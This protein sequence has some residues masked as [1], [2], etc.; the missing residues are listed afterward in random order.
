MKKLIWGTW[1]ASVLFLG[2]STLFAN[3]SFAQ[4]IICSG[5]GSSG[6]PCTIPIC[7]AEGTACLTALCQ[8][9]YGSRAISI[10]SGTTYYHT[11][12]G[13]NQVI[14]G[15]SSCQSS[16]SMYLGTIDPRSCNLSV[17]FSPSPYDFGPVMVNTVTSSIN[18]TIS[19]PSSIDAIGCQY[20]DTDVG[21]NFIFSSGN[22]A[23]L[24][25]GS[26]CVATLKANPKSAGTFTDQIIVACVDLNSHSFRY[27]SSNYSVTSSA[28]C[29]GGQ[30][31]SG[32]AC[33]CPYNYTFA[34][35][36]CTPNLSNGP[37]GSSSSSSTNNSEF[38]AQGGYPVCGSNRLPMRANL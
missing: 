2:M 18:V 38:F 28:A 37:A 29:T 1:L 10:A 23:N 12:G 21:T 22:C 24:P 3:D 9:A 33:V 19:N 17:T 13:V 31:L 5:N 34:A 36:I 35:G 30:Y 25:A 16:C 14:M 26:S 27:M 11:V 8:T 7:P 20:S 15:G 6:L 4:A 32:G